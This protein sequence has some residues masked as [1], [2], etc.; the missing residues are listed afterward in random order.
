[1]FFVSFLASLLAMGLLLFL[2]KKLV[3]ASAP[4]LPPTPA[5][6]PLHSARHQY[7]RT[8]IR[9]T[10]AAYDPGEE[11]EEEEE[12]EYEEVEDDDEPTE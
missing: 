3:G 5:P 7:V 12:E 4:K 8:N 10:P 2:T 1:M 6:A 9:R 11:E